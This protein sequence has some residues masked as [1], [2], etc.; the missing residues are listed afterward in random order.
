MANA[1]HYRSNLRDIVFNLFEVLDIGNTSLGKAPFA[2]LD[3]DTARELLKSHEVLCREELAKSFVEADRV[4]LALDA[5][6]NVTIPAGLKEAARAFYDGDWHLLALPE[7]MGGMGAPPSVGWAAFELCAGANA[8]LAFY[9]FGS[10]AARTIDRHGT[11]SQ[12]KRLGA[13]ILARR[14]GASMVL[15]EPDAGSDVGAGRTKARHLHDDVWEIHGTKR[16]I[17][18][19]DFDGVENIVHMVLARPEGAAEGTKGLSLFLVPKLWVEEDGTIGA[20]NGAFVTKVEKKMGIKGSST[21]EMTFGDRMPA[22]GLLLGNVHDGIRQMFHVIEQARMA[23]GMKSAAT[24]STAYLNAREYAKERIQGPDLTRAADKTSPRV[25]IVRHPDVR[26]MLMSQKAHAEGMR[27]LCLYTAWVQDQVEILGGHGDD[28]ADALDRRNDM[29]LPLVKGY[30]SEKAYEQLA[31]SLQTYGGSGYIQDYPIEQYLRDQK[32]DTLYEGTTHIQALD[33]V[34]RK[35]ARDG[36]ATLRALLGEVQATLASDAG[37]DALKE[38]RA[39]LGRAL[40]DLSGILGAMMEK[41]SASI[42]HVGLQ[43]NRILFAL[44]EVVIGWL[45][46]RQ[47]A[48][49]VA[50]REARPEDRAFYDGKIASARWWSKNVLPGLT[51]TRKLIE[52]SSL[53][54]MDLPDESF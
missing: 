11:E 33:L 18:N 22:R 10:F 41:M 32:I 7:S 49:A 51:L 5:D 19:G 15:T 37:G 46:L 21:C 12:K 16:F 40:A 17:T 13:P 35:I 28:R 43:G 1:L 30:C 52:Q 26:R 48:V 25:A 9:L 53:D 38:E 45:L 23:V 34:F 4:P 31:L 36:G 42:Y 50:A 2:A 47:A 3:A 39:A 54:L 14:W 29:L 6:G 8:T 44:A 24:L 20:R 27:A